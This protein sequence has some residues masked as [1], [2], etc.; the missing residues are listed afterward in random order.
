M[1]AAVLVLGSAAVTMR[2]RGLT[3][4]ADVAKLGGETYLIHDDRQGIGALAWEHVNEWSEW[5]QTPSGKSGEGRKAPFGVI[6]A[7]GLHCDRRSAKW[8]VASL[9][10]GIPAAVLDMRGSGQSKSGWYE[11]EFGKAETDED[12]LRE[13]SIV[14]SP[15]SQR[16]DFL[17]VADAAGYD[18]FV[19][20]GESN[21]AV[22]ALW[23]AVSEDTAPRV[24][25]LVLRKVPIMR[26]ER[27]NTWE[28]TTQPTLDRCFN[29]LANATRMVEEVCRA[30]YGCTGFAKELAAKNGRLGSDVPPDDMLMKLR[31]KIPVLVLAVENEK[32]HPVESGIRVAN[33]TGGQLHVSSTYEQARAEWPAIMNA[34]TRKLA[35]D[36]GMKLG[37]RRNPE[38]LQPNPDVCMGVGRSTEFMD[39]RCRDNE[40][41][42]RDP[43]AF[44]AATG[45][46][47]SEC[48][49][50][51]A[52]SSAVAAKFIEH[53]LFRYHHHHH[54]DYNNTGSD[55]SNRTDASTGS[56]AEGVDATN[57]TSLNA[58]F[59]TYAGALEEYEC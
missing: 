51:N 45:M 56:D 13:V 23:A 25:G 24:S 31:G 37:N 33:L 10:G 46:R 38:K 27:R 22:A 44:F 39:E 50:I 42:Y 19:L 3:F 20:N 9:D 34:F 5:E 16:R 52:T 55:A 8:A 4:F 30:G 47:F 29:N 41:K 57:M 21:S 26:E 6:G 59:G 7:H 12:V 1:C 40:D 32:S 36:S 15:R 2:V 49:D 35:T 54:D 48:I 53:V 14:F 58:V 18:K 11:M 17:A 43:A 28:N